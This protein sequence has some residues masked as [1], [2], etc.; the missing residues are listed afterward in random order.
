MFFNRIRS[1]KTLE[2]QEEESVM[3]KRAVEYNENE[4]RQRKE[5]L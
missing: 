3:M 2:Y 4:G 1:R 5:N